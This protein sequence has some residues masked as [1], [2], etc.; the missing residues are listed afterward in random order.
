LQYLLL[1]NQNSLEKIG[2]GLFLHFR[3][4]LYHPIKFEEIPINYNYFQNGWW[5]YF[6]NQDA[7][8][9]TC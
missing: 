4:F 7:K 5:G 8:Q 9:H 3:A 1:I 2:G 6:R